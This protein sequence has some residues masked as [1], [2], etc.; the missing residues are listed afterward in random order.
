MLTEEVLAAANEPSLNS[1]TAKEFST[2]FVP[3]MENEPSLEMMTEAD[4][5]SKSPVDFGITT[6]STGMTSC[7]DQLS[8]PIIDII[9]SKNDS[10]NDNRHYFVL[11][12]GGSIVRALCDP[13]DTIY[14]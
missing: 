3:I 4:A 10:H 7:D 13:G 1:P 8:H 11:I 14:M 2:E 12:F 9:D 6:S 5:I